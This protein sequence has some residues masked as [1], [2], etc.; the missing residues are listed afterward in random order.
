MT[1]KS[2]ST[3]ILVFIL[4]MT[5]LTVSCRQHRTPKSI[6]FKRTTNIDSNPSE[7]EQEDNNIVKQEYL[8]VN[9]SLFKICI[10]APLSNTSEQIIRRKAYVLSYNK[11]TK[12]PYWVAWHLTA[13]HTDGVYKRMNTYW[14]DN[15]VPSPRATDMD[16]QGSGM[17]HGH[18][19]P[20]G[21]NKWDVEAMRESNILTNICPQ[22]GRL[23]TGLWN[24]IEQDCRVWAR[25]YGDVFIVCGPVLFNREHETI[26]KN[27][28]VVPEAFFK[29]VLRM[30]PSPRALG[31]IVRNNNGSK[32]RDQFVNSVDEVE[33]ITGI[34]FFP[35][36]PDSIENVVESYAN[37]EDWK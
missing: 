19:C 22:E 32:K 4:S 5:T 21:D 7:E 23:N 3:I 14:E 25:K 33:R 28:I 34:D 12:L 26:G 18:M 15:D 37:L 20:A 17:T 1:T 36:L 11:N 9:D 2:S 10:P 29:V 24:R 8:Y 13:E 31:F 6:T 27:K 30:H 16:Y 35:S